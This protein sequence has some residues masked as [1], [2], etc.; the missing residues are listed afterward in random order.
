M[1]AEKQNKAYGVLIFFV[2]ILLLAA[3]FGL[4]YMFKQSSE[5]LIS[6]QSSLSTDKRQLDSQ[7][8]LSSRYDA[9]HDLTQGYSG[10]ERQFPVNG[11]L[12]FQAL[13]SVM[14]DYNIEFV[15][16]G[17]TVG[18]QPGANFTLQI[19]FSGQYYNL[20]KAL[21]AIRESGFIMRISELNL[22]AE[23]NGVVNG[24]MSIISTAA[25]A[26]S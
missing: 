23:G 15:N 3:Q 13:N 10:A 5:E 19:R 24:T 17:S 6:I 1:T 7:R 18:V 25:R 12:L 14:Q 8:S 22:N 2:V 4:Q 20:M 16:A 9:F 21:A 11:A 26:Q